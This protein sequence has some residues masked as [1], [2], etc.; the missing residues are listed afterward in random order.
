MI[1]DIS[2]PVFGCRVYPGDPLPEK[3]L[4]SDMERG[5]LYDLTVFSMCAHNGTHI[6]APLHFI[7]NG[8]SVDEIPPEKCVG[9]AFVCAHAGDVTAEDAERILK[10]AEAACPNAAKRILIKG[11][12][13]VTEEAAQ[14]FAAAGLYLLGNESQSIGP[15]D[16]PMAVHKVLLGAETVL[17]EGIVLKEVPEGV[18]TLNCLPLNLNGAEGAP[19]R[20]ILT[21]H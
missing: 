19:C 5:D 3:K 15:M 18:Y 1:Y 20:A 17:L 4:L 14:I 7:Q 2:Q 8:K 6:D 16:A 12:A 13:T 9:A 11:E 10:K 21:D